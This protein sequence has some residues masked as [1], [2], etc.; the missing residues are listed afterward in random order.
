MEVVV[1]EE[2]EDPKQAIT[3]ALGFPSQVEG[4]TQG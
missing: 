2:P 4:K 1:G 3:I